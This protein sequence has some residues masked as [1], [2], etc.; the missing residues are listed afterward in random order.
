MIRVAR[1]GNPEFTRR[2]FH[3]TGIVAPFG[4]AAAAACLLDYDPFQTQNALCLCC[5]WGGRVDGFLPERG[6]ASRCRSAVVRSG[7]GGR[8]DRG[9]GGTGLPEILE[10]GSIRPTWGARPIPPSITP[11]NLNM[12]FREAI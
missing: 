9:D 6:N 12:P 1:G 3:P 7:T 10:E 11:W 8:P 5:A 2:G 4:A